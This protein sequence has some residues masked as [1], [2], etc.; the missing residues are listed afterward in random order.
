MKIELNIMKIHALFEIIPKVKAND[1]TVQKKKLQHQTQQA[2]PFDLF[3]EFKINK[4]RD[5]T[6]HM[7]SVVEFAKRNSWWSV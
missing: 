3:I 5:E 2:N 4:T 1:Q 6:E 7:Y